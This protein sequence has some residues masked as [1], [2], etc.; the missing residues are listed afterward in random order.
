MAF[1]AC[2]V[3][4]NGRLGDLSRGGTPRHSIPDP[5]HGAPARVPGL[6]DLSPRLRCDHPKAGDQSREVRSV[7]EPSIAKSISTINIVQLSDGR[8]EGNRA[9]QNWQAKANS[10]FVDDD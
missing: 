6:S 9:M 7:A 5:L 4:I 2:P 8:I 10:C 3:A 1:R